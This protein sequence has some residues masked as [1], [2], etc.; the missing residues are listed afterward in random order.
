MVGVII[1]SKQPKTE[2]AHV[3]VKHDTVELASY[4]HKG[5]CS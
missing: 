2:T 1:L 4:H 3:S 5:R